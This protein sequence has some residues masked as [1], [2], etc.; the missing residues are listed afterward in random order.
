MV[1][2]FWQAV[3]SVTEKA[4]Q[5]SSFVWADAVEKDKKDEK[6]RREQD[7]EL[8]SNMDEGYE[9]GEPDYKTMHQSKQ[10]TS[11][12]MRKIIQKHSEK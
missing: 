2:P 12:R 3:Q 7:N 5:L 10:W 8:D 1:L 9:L 4:D 6:D 11:E